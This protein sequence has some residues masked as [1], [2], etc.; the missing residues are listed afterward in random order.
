M[1]FN[2]HTDLDGMHAFLSP[3]G[4]HWLNYDE[5]K[6]KERYTTAQAAAE[7]TEIHEFASIAIKKRF[8]V[9]RN[10]KAMYMFI[11]DAIGYRMES[12]QPLFY[13]EYCFGTAD[14]ISFRD[15]KLMIFDLKTGRTKASFAQLDV[16][17]ALFCLEYGY[18]PNDIE[19]EE[20]IYQGSE[21]IINIPEPETIKEAMSVIVK[22]DSTLRRLQNEV[23]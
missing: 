19:I 21:A 14:A 4:Y 15:N 2:K 9:A 11:N 7:G 1:K 5:N 20:R 3:S 10:K 8:K 6:L 17:A 23:L 18:D 16:Y 12:E 22:H 13:S